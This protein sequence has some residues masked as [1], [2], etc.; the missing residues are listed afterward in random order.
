MLFVF[1]LA[2]H[3]KAVLILFPGSQTAPDMALRFVDIKDLAG[4]LR[5]EGVN[6]T[7]A[8]CAVFMYG[9]R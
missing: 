3:L 6:G 5:Q 7:E 4:L 8:F 2:A 9:C 1:L